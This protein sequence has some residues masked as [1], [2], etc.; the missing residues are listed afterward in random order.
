MTQLGLGLICAIFC[1]GQLPAQTDEPSPSE[2]RSIDRDL[3]AQE[4]KA[5]ERDLRP[6]LLLYR[7]S[8]KPHFLL[9]YVLFRENRPAESLAEYTA[10]AAVGTASV[11]DLLTVCSDYILLKDY[12][13][14]EHWLLY[15]AQHFQTEHRVWYLLGRTQYRLDQAAEAVASYQKSL[16]LT[17][18]DLPSQYNLG[19]A[20]EKLGKLADAEAAY[21]TAMS[22]QRETGAPDPQPYLDL[23]ILLMSLHRNEEALTQLMEAAALGPKN[24]MVQQQLGLALETLGRNN[25]AAAALQRAVSLSPAAGQPHLYLGRIYRR[26]GRKDDAA[27]Q[28]AEAQHLYGTRS[29]QETP[30]EPPLADLDH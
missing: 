2:L 28:F 21:R 22:L 1:S 14:A 27:A 16:Q 20:L 4:W 23:G 13:D 26:L 12:A 11:N 15:T 8:A 24:A 19:L 29:V 30:N 10:A 7:A 3:E 9:G 25:E 6:L 5:A 18:R 17:P